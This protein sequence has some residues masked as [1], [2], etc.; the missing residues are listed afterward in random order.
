MRRAWGPGVALVLVGSRA[1]AEDTSE[2]KKAAGDEVVV[3]AVAVARATPSRDDSVPGT[4]VQGARLRAPGARAADVLRGL[5]GLTVIDGG[6]YG[7]LATASI[8]GA[9]SA[10]T[11]VY[12][13]GVRLND[14]VGGTAD[15]STVPLEMVERV[16]VYRGHAPVQADRM[17]LG[18]AIFFDPPTVLRP[19]TGAT[20]TAGS[21]GLRSTRLRASLGDASAGVLASFSGQQ[22]T[23]DY[24]YRD[25]RGTR[26]DTGDDRTVRRRNADTRSREVWVLG[27]AR[28]DR[29]TRVLALAS[30]I[31]REQGVPGL[32]VL[33]TRAA[34]TALE[35]QLGAVRAER[36]CD[37]DRCALALT[38]TA[39]HA[40]SRIHDPRRELA[41]GGT[42]QRSEGSRVEQSATLRHD[43]GER[44]SVQ[45]ALDVAVERLALTLDRTV[46]ST[47]RF[48][49]AAAAVAWAAPGVTL[50]GLVAGECHGVAPGAVCD[51]PVPAARLGAQGRLGPGDWLLNAGR[52][53]RA[54]TLGER[55]GVSALVRGNPSLRPESGLVADAGWRGSGEPGG[56][57]VALEV[58]GFVQWIDDLVVYQRSSLGYLRPYNVGST[59]TLGFEGSARA[60]PWPWLRLELAVTLL[61]PRDTSSSRQGDNTILPF[62]NRL[63]AAPAVELRPGGWRAIGLDETSVEARYLHQSSRYGDTA[64][65]V[66]LPSQGSL[67]VDLGTRWWRRRVGVR[68]RAANV[69]DQRR[70]DTVGYPLPGRSFFASLD[71][72]GP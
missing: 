21:F 37:D 31:D 40:D 68:V 7:A 71:L 33:P 22:A 26:F 38:T 14:D 23:N 17:A 64:G 62:R 53:G 56:V 32:G 51:L 48:S 2:P 45:G 18:G 49:R 61:D 55:D 6:G 52:Y 11:P 9:T 25:D 35:R 5:P 60:A 3:R 34:R 30:A 57:P 4:V 72:A 39:I 10:Q 47:R 19:A 29:S 46:V 12:L 66:V 65:Q 24:A 63:Q 36:R 1:S 58:F 42:D 50:R 16:E 41:L 13:A 70:S 8:R 44:V 67:D 69:L 15:L 54:P 27:Q 59:R 20:L 43:V 28:A